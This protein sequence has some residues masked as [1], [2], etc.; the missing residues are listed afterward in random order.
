[1]PNARRKAAPET[2]IAIATASAT[3]IG[4]KRTAAARRIA[5]IA[6]KCIPEMATPATAP[7]TSARPPLTSRLA[8]V[9]ATADKPTATT[10]ESASPGPP[11]PA[12]RPRPERAAAAD[13]PARQG[14]GHGRQADRHDHRERSDGHAV[15]HGH[16]KVQREHRH[17]VH[18]PD[19][20]P[21]RQG[22]RDQPDR[23]RGDAGHPRA[24]RETL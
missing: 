6:V 5:A 3:R 7:A 18:A 1:M 13:V 19:G 11:P 20:D 22:A 24:P 14:E 17:E 4:S 9:K 21:H 15:A 23:A 16:R 8:R 2:T 10:T 12:T